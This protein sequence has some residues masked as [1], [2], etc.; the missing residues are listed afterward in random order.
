MIKC[1]LCNSK[2]TTI[3]ARAKDI[4]Y[5]TSDREFDIRA[6]KPCGILFVDP[7]LSDKL[8]DIYPA[9][10]YSFKVTKR[11]FVVAVKEWLDRRGLKALTRQIPGRDL[12]VLDIGG[13]TGWLLDQV[14]TAD[15]RVSHTTVVDI[16]DGARD[17][18]ISKGHDFHLSRFED[19][20]AGD[21]KFD[22][23]LM[24]NLVEHVTDPRA[25][26]SKAAS[27]LS[28]KG[29]I[30]VKTPNF[31]SLDAR[32]FR[33][34]SWAGYHTP[35]HF[36]IFNRDSLERTARESGLAVAN[37]D[38]TQGAPFWSISI[39]DTLRRIGVVQASADKPAIYHPVTPLL[40]AG[41]A[42]FDFARKPFGARLSQMVLTL[43]RRP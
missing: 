20:D 25:V 31:D 5:F 30:W 10:Y 12:S 40:Q 3:H 7:M 11:N 19:F 34:H 43:K 29:L 38:Y 33:N 27:L 24:L 8:G 18:A 26:L 15:S 13:G 39:F 23:I 32:L 42:A 14:K 16:D 35:R 28:P 4:E 17:V 1:P 2:E 21:R 37:F 22:L 6:C 41:A 36:V 9:N